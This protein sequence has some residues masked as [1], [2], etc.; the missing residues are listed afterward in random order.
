MEFAFDVCLRGSIRVDAPTEEAA[1][2][3]LREHLDCADANLGAW[4]NGEPILAEV[5]LWPEGELCQPN[6]FEIDGEAV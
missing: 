2:A 3:M 4:P 1:R 5:S 6:L